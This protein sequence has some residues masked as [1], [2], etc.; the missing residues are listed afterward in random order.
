MMLLKHRVTS[1]N[2]DRKISVREFDEQV[3]L[4]EEQVREEVLQ[5][6]TP[7]EKTYRRN[8]ALASLAALFFINL[9]LLCAEA[10]LPTF[11]DDKYNKDE[12]GKK[13]EHEVI[14]EDQV[15]LILA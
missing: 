6:L 10:V 4:V 13:K 15:S 8:V 7:E 2:I 5:N 11:I 9:L 14:S 12:E 3:K 1:M